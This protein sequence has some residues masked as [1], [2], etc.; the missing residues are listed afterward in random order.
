MD[1]PFM[2]GIA[3]AAFVAFGV[4]TAAAAA[5]DPADPGAQVVSDS[6]SPT[7]VA[8]PT[9]GVPHLPSPDHLPP[10]TTQAAPEQR[11]LG[12][13]RDLV[14]AV[15]A[16]DVTMSDAAML[17]LTHRPSDARV[18]QPDSGPHVQSGADPALTAPAPADAAAASPPPETP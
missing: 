7:A 4:L 14:Q 17:L 16:Q 1:R 18:A 8:S 6:A 11:S 5:A 10:G 13:L 2:A 3:T 9:G 15:R 12:Y